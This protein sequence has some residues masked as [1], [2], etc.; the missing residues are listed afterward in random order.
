MG[1]SSNWSRAPVVS[2]YAKEAPNG[3]RDD[4]EEQVAESVRIDLEEELLHEVTKAA[5]GEAR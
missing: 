4:P 1:R 5:W 3:M 2:G